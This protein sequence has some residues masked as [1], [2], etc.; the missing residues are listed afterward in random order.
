M[1]KELL[2]LIRRWSKRAQVKSDKSEKVERQALASSSLAAILEAL[3]LTREARV[4]WQCTLDLQRLMFRQKNKQEE[5]RK[6]PKMHGHS[7]W[8]IT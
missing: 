2:Q 4:I 1:N 5:K 6:S 3:C 8:P 7:E